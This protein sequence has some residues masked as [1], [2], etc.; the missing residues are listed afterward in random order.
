MRRL[1]VTTYTAKVYLCMRMHSIRM[2]YNVKGPRYAQPHCAGEYILH[3]LPVRNY[4]YCKGIYMQANTAY[5]NFLYVKRQL[6]R[7]HNRLCKVSMVTALRRETCAQADTS[8][9]T[10]RVSRHRGAQGEHGEPSCVCVR[11]CAR[12]AHR[13]IDRSIYPLIYPSIHLCIEYYLSLLPR[14]T[15]LQCCLA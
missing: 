11:A 6:V 7:G 2:A 12:G 5:M 15:P 4:T 14:I 3:A 13:S 9:D 1:Y 10:S 8:R